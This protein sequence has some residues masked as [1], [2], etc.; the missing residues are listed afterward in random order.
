M[1]LKRRK[2]DE[3]TERNLDLILTEV[4]DASVYSGMLFCDILLAKLYLK[5]QIM[6]REV[7][8][9]SAVM[10]VSLILTKIFSQS[11]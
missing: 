4:P 5:N 1:R 2:N 8:W 11:S 7:I 6:L 9:S 10:S 3:R